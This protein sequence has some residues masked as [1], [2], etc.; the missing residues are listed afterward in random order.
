MMIAMCRG[1]RRV[2]GIASVELS[3]KLQPSQA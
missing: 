3:N 1:T 2:S